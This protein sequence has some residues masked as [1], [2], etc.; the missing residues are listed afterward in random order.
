MSRVPTAEDFVAHVGTAVTPKGQHRG[1]TLVSVDTMAS[2][3]QESPPREA[4]SLILRGPPDDVLPEGLYDFAFGDGPDAAEGFSMYI[5][6]V[7]TPARDRQD[8]QI[9]FN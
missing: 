7:H 9:V 8:Y 6:P 2:P 4:F 1:L 5:A 3:G